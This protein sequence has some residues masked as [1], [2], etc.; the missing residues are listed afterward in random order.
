MQIPASAAKLSEANQKLEPPSKKG[1]K[2][3]KVKEVEIDVPWEL[4]TDVSGMRVNKFFPTRSLMQRMITRRPTVDIAQRTEP[5]T[6]RL[7]H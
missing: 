5:Q 6:P 3:K 4:P 1:H 7:R 2:K